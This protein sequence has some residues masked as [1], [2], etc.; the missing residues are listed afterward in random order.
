M[1]RAE[2]K[3]AAQLCSVDTKVGVRVHDDTTR[4]TLMEAPVVLWATIAAS[5][6]RLRPFK[7]KTSLRIHHLFPFRLQAPRTVDEET[8][9]FQL[10]PDI[11]SLATLPN[12][13]ACSTY[14]RFF[15]F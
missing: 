5:S 6:V 11:R 9:A 14:I 3:A 4:R 2:A 8:N 10:M 12:C 7:K 15:F 1:R 13:L